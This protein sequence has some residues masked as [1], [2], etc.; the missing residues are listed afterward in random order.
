M[1]IKNYKLKINLGSMGITLIEL[2]V[3]MT[4]IAIISSTIFASRGNMENEL[5]LQRAA[6]KLSQDFREAAEM[7]MGS[8]Q[9]SCSV[10]KDVCG[11]GLYFEKSTYGFF[12]DCAPGCDTSNHKK[13]GQ[14]D[15]ELRQV[16]LEGDIEIPDT[17]PNKVDVL[18]C[19]P[20]PAIYINGVEW[21]REAI[22]TLELNSETR[23]VRINSAG[24]IEIE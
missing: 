9:G 10:G 1:K 11:F 13:D 20:E 18:F 3:T 21:D 12:I 22:M 24:R 15:I 16:V 2:L 8:G 23:N 4:I 14:D 19:P 7:A 6:Y 5:A 17:S